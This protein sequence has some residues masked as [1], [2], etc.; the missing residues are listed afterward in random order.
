ME[1]LP[2]SRRA[3]FSIR[4]TAHCPTIE[5]RVAMVSMSLEIQEMPGVSRQGGVDAQTASMIRAFPRNPSY[6]RIGRRNRIR[7][8]FRPLQ[9]RVNSRLNRSRSSGEGSH[10]RSAKY[11]EPEIIEIGH[12]IGLGPQPNT[13]LFESFI[14]QI[15][16]WLVVIEDADLAALVDHAQAV[17]LSDVDD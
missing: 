16:D 14:T 3:T 8:L 15:K 5:R 4:L 2:M 12:C 9:Q 7:R 17:P 11:C 10:A 6:S 1:L 13:A